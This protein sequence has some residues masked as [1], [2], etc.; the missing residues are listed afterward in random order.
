[1]FVAI[2]ERI[3]FFPYFFMNPN[4]VGWAMVFVWFGMLLAVFV[5]LGFLLLLFDRKRG[6]A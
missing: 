6:G 4:E 5:G 3:N 1:V 2:G